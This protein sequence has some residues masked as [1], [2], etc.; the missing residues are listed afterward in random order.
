M[1]EP[2]NSPASPA[3]DA[4]APSVVSPQP[5]DLARPL[6]ITRPPVS[7]YRLMLEDAWDGWIRQIFNARTLGGL[8]LL[9]YFEIIGELTISVAVGLALVFLPLVVAGR[10]AV[11]L[12]NSARLVAL[13]W[14]NVTASAILAALCL[15]ATLFPGKLLYSG[16][17][18]AVTPQATLSLPA[19]ADELELLV[20]GHLQDVGRAGYDLSLLAPDKPVWVHG[21]VAKVKVPQRVGRKTVQGAILE[22]GSTRFIL[23]PTSTPTEIKLEHKEGGLKSLYVSLHAVWLPSSWVLAAAVSLIVAACYLDSKLATRLKPSYLTIANSVVLIS[24][25]LYFRNATPDMMLKNLV[26]SAMIGA[27]GGTFGGLLL[28]SLGK[29]LWASSPP[30]LSE[31]VSPAR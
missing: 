19:D 27:L 4:S 24:F 28:T 9:Y 18:N 20:S 30:A 25:F 29:R 10:H 14:L 7:H 23:H 6:V 8:G 26:G 17:L 12:A 22:E 21:E 16:T 1:E 31:S 13:S 5:S 11:G 2:V 15:L 3:T